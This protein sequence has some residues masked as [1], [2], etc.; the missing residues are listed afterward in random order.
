MSVFKSICADLGENPI[1]T[2]VSFGGGYQ[3]PKQNDT[4]FST[5]PSLEEKK[6]STATFKQEDLNSSKLNLLSSLDKEISKL[7]GDSNTLAEFRI[8]FAPDLAPEKLTSLEELEKLKLINQQKLKVLESEYLQ[9]IQGKS[10]T[11]DLLKE[12]SEYKA[13]KNLSKNKFTHNLDYSH[14]K[15]YP[16]DKETLL[17][18]IFSKLDVDS[19]GL[20]EKH[21]ML[22]EINENKELKEYFGIE[23][24]LDALEEL[25]FLIP[26][27]F[28]SQD[29]FIKFFLSIKPS[30]V[31]SSIQSEAKPLEVYPDNIKN[32]YEYPIVTLTNKQLS[33]LERVFKETDIH[34]DMAIQ[35]FEYLQSLRTDDD[36]IKTL[37]CHAIEIS[38]N[39][40][41]TLEEALDRIQDSEDLYEYITYSQFL[42]YFYIMFPKQTWTPAEIPAKVNLDPLYVQI[43]Q[44]IFDSIP[45]KSKG[46]VSTKE[47]VDSLKEDPQAQEFFKVTVQGKD[48]VEKI[49]NFIDQQSAEVISWEDFIAYFS[50]NKR[51]DLKTQDITSVNRG[52]YYAMKQDFYKENKSLSPQTSK[53]KFKYK[54]YS[55][56]RDLKADNKKHSKSVMKFTVPV[57]FEFENREKFKNKSIRQK[58]FEDYIGEIRLEEENHIKY[59]PKASPVPAEVSIP[60]YNTMLAA[61]RARRDEIKQNSK[62]M[63]KQKEKPF[64]FYLRELNKPKLE[65][66]KEEPY[67]FKAKP[68]PASNSIPLYE[69]M[70]RKLED[71]RKSRIESAARKALEEAKMPSRMERHMKGNKNLSS[72]PL[73]STVFKAKKPP[74]FAKLWDNLGKSLEKKKQSFQPTQPKEFNFGEVKKRSTSKGPNSID[75]ELVQK[76]FVEILKNKKINSLDPP[77]DLPKPTKKQTDNEENGKKRREEIKKQDE[78]RLKQLEEKKQADEDWKKKIELKSQKDAENTKKKALEGKEKLKQMDEKY[79]N[80]KEKML[81][82]IKNRPGPADLISSEYSKTNSQ[83][84]S[85]TSIKLKMQ[86]RGIPISNIIGEQDGFIDIIAEDLV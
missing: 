30:K 16:N 25:S 29:D 69:H 86:A 73:P 62:D 18:W 70:S 7:R 42:N 34:G 61:Q 83:P 49:I 54:Y 75:E 12:Y 43:L 23:D 65:E 74:E 17:K 44:D 13:N 67:K 19:S 55:P 28:L 38:Q 60:K 20:I 58:K 10:Q 2:R 72:L 51:P 22:N 15:D 48:T 24:D 3:M 71:D 53:K 46:L 39:N 33:H 82:N 66:I 85:L 35:K 40:F 5:K 9:K 31:P 32:N 47:L 78:D 64:D 50:D 79:S 8:K 37:D 56:G 63:T 14:L 27:D 84:R 1:P 80:D 57:A 11:K 36:I 76:G 26:S 21:E 59:H 68:P 6:R 77:K 4:K 52:N 45:R 41:I 81:E